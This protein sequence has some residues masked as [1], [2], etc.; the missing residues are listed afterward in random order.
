L[1][2]Q[3]HPVP[4]APTGWQSLFSGS[5]RIASLGFLTGFGSGFHDATHPGNQADP[6]C[7]RANRHYEADG[8]NHS[9][10][11]FQQALA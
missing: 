8:L 3:S 7:E 5:H 4:K 11:D 1:K 2:R 9:E 10:K 6:G